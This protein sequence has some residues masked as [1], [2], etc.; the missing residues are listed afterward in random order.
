MKYYITLIALLSFTASSSGNLIQMSEYIL[1][2]DEIDDDLTEEK[3][4]LFT[5]RISDV[6]AKETSEIIY[7]V[8]GKEMTLTPG[9]NTEII[10]RV[11][12]GKHK[13]NFVL[14]LNH[15]EIMTDEIDILEGHHQ[16]YQLNFSY[17]AQNI[18]LRKPVIY[19][20]PEEETEVNISVESEGKLTFMYPSYTDSWTVTAHPSGEI[21]HNDESYNYLFWE[22]ENTINENAIDD[23]RGFLIAQEELVSFLETTLTTYGYT[24][25]EQADFITYWVPNMKDATNLYIYFLFDEACEQFATLNISPKPTNTARLYM[26]WATAEANYEEIGIA[27]QDIP[28]INR[29]GFTVIEWGG[30]EMNAK[31]KTID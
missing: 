12:P 8:D 27:P 14:S 24:S 10:I 20:Y 9:E 11:E 26:L 1:I 17:S 18:H 6:D 16:I 31:S 3:M 30:A 15:F 22:G 13:F 29:E 23:T 5:F 2:A 7:S 25:K 28:T 19:L 21:T 4:S